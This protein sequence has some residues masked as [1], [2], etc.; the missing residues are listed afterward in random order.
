MKFFVL[1]FFLTIGT[2]TAIANS[3]TLFGPWSQNAWMINAYLSLK[4][5]TL[6]IESWPLPEGF[7]KKY[8]PDSI[9]D[10]LPSTSTHFFF[11]FFPELSYNN[12]SYYPT[13]TWVDLIQAY[14]YDAMKDFADFG[15]QTSVGNDLYALIDMDI[16]KE[17]GN[18]FA[19]D[20]V[21]NFPFT[22]LDVF[23]PAI[24]ANFPN[25]GYISYFNGNLLL[26][27]GR[28]KLSWGP[29]TDGLALSDASPYYD[30]GSFM[31]T[32]PADFIKRFSFTFNAISVD[33]ELTPEEYEIQSTS[34]D[35]IA[36]NAVYN[37]PSKFLFAHRI[38]LQIFKNL[39]I[40]LGELKLLGGKYP[41]F[42]DFNPFIIWHNTYG[43]GY[44]NDMG[45][46]DF[47][48]V[49]VDGINVY[50]EFA[51]DQ[52]TTSLIAGQPINYKPRAYA[53]A[54]GLT[55]NW[56]NWD[57]LSQ[58]GVEYYYVTPWMYNRWQPY[59][60][61]T[62][63]IMRVSENP[64]SRLFTDYPFGYLY[65]PDVETLSFFFNNHNGPLDTNLAFNWIQKG[66]IT[67]L[68]PYNPN[69]YMAT[70]PTGTA[71]D[72]KDFSATFNYNFTKSTSLFFSG[73]LRY[74]MN[75][76]NQDTPNTPTVLGN[77]WL[78]DFSFGIELKANY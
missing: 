6:L 70:T 40:G 34:P 63:R 42:R 37:E 48:Y 29:M 13:S 25:E 49:P 26:Q 9:S 33:P 69:D 36:G 27:A 51:L 28:E 54:Y 74:V 75:Y 52:L 56:G 11:K 24:D 17:M 64:G 22:Y 58:I 38:D 76:Q 61:F 35:P 21:T 47:N 5:E 45:D 18:F 12:W 31:Y 72:I 41:D 2:I 50:G 66:Q 14:R 68:T 20:D 7:I 4:G 57:D 53:Y 73:D 3:A 16:R 10:T 39:R 8:V 59:L 65:G 44:S 77:V 60:E 71:E 78:Y 30:Q 67:T 15:F 1:S 19:K 23:S 62:N 55:K 46:F 43:E 32:T